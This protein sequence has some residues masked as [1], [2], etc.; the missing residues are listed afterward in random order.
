MMVYVL[1]ETKSSSIRERSSATSKDPVSTKGTA[2]STSRSSSQSPTKSCSSL[3]LDRS[4]PMSGDGY[5][6][7][8]EIQFQARATRTK[9]LSLARPTTSGI[10]SRTSKRTQ[11]AAFPSS[12]PSTGTMTV[13]LTWTLWMGSGR[14]PIPTL[15]QST[16]SSP[17]PA[18][19]S[20]K[21]SVLNING[22]IIQ[23]TRHGLS[24]TAS[25]SIR[26]LS[27]TTSSAL[28]IH[29]RIVFLGPSLL[30][31][32]M[33]DGDRAGVVLFRYAAAW[34]GIIKSGNSTRAAMVNNILM[35]PDDG[36]HTVNKGDEIASV[37]VSGGIV[38]LH[39]EVGV[40]SFYNQEGRFSY[41]TDGVNF[42]PLGEPHEEID[43]GILHFMGYRYGVFNY[44][45]LARGGAVTVKSLSIH[46]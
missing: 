4:D 33:A 8:M 9:A 24:T 42:E 6:K 19:T 12:H 31:L 41:S 23:I 14:A 45:T 20:S 36:W 3:Q 43:R 28:E 30:S 32:R 21:H 46:E 37:E 5:C 27:R 17:S 10:T 44:A 22:T 2:P 39:L 26:R 16:Q 38:W 7:A 29:S 11:E 13:G 40:N 15:S 18:Q 34:I 35:I 25:S 1:S